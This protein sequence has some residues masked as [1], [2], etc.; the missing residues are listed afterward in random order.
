MKVISISA[1]D[2]DTGLCW[3][4]ISLNGRYLGGTFH[5]ESA[6][7]DIIKNPDGCKIEDYR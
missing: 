1:K 4:A 2:K 5:D 3:T 6:V 7:E